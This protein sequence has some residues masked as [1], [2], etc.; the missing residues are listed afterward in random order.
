MFD[1]HKFVLDGLLDSVGNWPDYKVIFNALG[2]QDKGVLDD[3]DMGKIQ[4]AID[5]KNAPPVEDP[6]PDMGVIPEVTA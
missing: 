3:S 5:A 1:L 4:T 2:W 6:A